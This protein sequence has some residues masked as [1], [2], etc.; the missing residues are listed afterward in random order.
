MAI[1]L[2]GPI[3]GTSFTIDKVEPDEKNESFSVEY[4]LIDNPFNIA[5]DHPELVV[6]VEEI[7]T[8]ALINAAKAAEA[9]KAAGQKD[10]A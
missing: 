10:E 2:D 9:R 7:F 4:T 3:K 8:Q 1:V 5:D 6:L